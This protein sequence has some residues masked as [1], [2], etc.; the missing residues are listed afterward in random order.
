M[1]TTYLD[2]YFQI[3]VVAQ[4]MGEP[5]LSAQATVTVNVIRNTHAPEFSPS[6]YA[7]NIDFNR[8]IGEEI[9]A[10]FAQDRD[11]EV[12]MGKTIKAWMILRKLY[13]N[14]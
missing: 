6:Q 1:Y 11:A 13:I 9:E 4:D 12:W 3:T 2:S 8:P 14:E 10:V 7:K 5:P